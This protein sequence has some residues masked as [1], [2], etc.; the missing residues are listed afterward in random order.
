VNSDLWSE[1]KI[2]VCRC[3]ATYSRP[4]RNPSPLNSPC[5]I[6][7]PANGQSECSSSIRRIKAGSPCSAFCGK[8]GARSVNSAK[9]TGP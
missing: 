4:V 5:T 1:L 3:V 7:L 9:L 8:N 2:S 6:R